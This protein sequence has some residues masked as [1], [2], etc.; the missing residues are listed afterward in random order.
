VVTDSYSCGSG[1]C[2]G[3]EMGSHPAGYVA[4]VWGA[5]STGLAPVAITHPV[6]PVSTTNLTFEHTSSFDSNGVEYTGDNGYV[7]TDSYSC[8]SGAC[9]GFEMGSHPAGYVAPVWGADSTGL[10]PVAVTQAPATSLTGI[11]PACAPGT[12]GSDGTCFTV[13]DPHHA[14]E[15]Y[16]VWTNEYEGK[17]TL[18][19][20]APA[21]PVTP[22]LKEAPM[23]TSS[24]PCRPHPSHFVLCGH[25]MV[26]GALSATQA[27]GQ[28]LLEG[29]PVASDEWHQ[30]FSKVSE[31]AVNSV[32]PVGGYILKQSVL[33]K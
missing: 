15:G 25:A 29:K 6:D 14:G 19:E 9:G 8:G 18:P 5:D 11:D 33:S 30:E 28:K 10:A 7:V 4:P 3:F 2:G 13:E 1:A 22:E 12:G 23:G 32:S 24:K 21:A 16:T 17:M 27:V 20:L 26:L 31:E